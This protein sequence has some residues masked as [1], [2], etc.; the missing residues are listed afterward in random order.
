MIS[1]TQD[2][3][4]EHLLLQKRVEAIAS[5]PRP[6]L[7]D[8]RLHN[9]ALVLEH[10]Q[11]PETLRAVEEAAAANDVHPTNRRLVG[12]DGDYKSGKSN[13]AIRLAGRILARGLA[14]Q[15]C[16]VSDGDTQSDV[17]PVIYILAVASGEADLATRLCRSLGVPVG[18]TAVAMLDRAADQAS[19]S[20]VDLCVFDD[21]NMF[22][23]SRR[24]TAIRQFA[25][26]LHNALPTM[27]WVG[28]GLPECAVL[29]PALSGTKADAD[30]GRQLRRRISVVR[31][32]SI[33]Q[34]RSGAEDFFTL[35]Q[36][37]SGRYLLRT[38]DPLRTWTGRDYSWLHGATG[39]CIGT[40][41]EVLNHAAAVA[42]GTTEEL[43]PDLVRQKFAELN[44]EESPR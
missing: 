38:D 4:L 29:N 13:L 2:G 27:L 36:R 44:T 11:F 25:K 40:L 19:R 41:F 42:V 10:P 24:L 14:G 21:F 7:E 39:G 33:P 3:L 1:T 5:A 6:T 35:L 17:I 9:H 15:P 22:E 20:L 16:V 30:A 18:G 23:S 12:L 37:C 43:S 28:K 34:T 8:R 32:R 31:L 26:A